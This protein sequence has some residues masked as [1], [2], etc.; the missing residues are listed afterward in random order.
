MFKLLVPACLSLMVMCPINLQAQDCGCNH[1]GDD[2]YESGDD[3]DSVP[4][5]KRIGLIESSIEIKK[6]R[7]VCE[8]DECGNTRYRLACVSEPFTFKRLGLVDVPVD[9][10]RPSFLDQMRDRMS[11]LSLRNRF[12]SDECCDDCSEGDWGYESDYGD[13]TQGHFSRS[14]PDYDAE[15]Y[16]EEEAGY[17][18]GEVVPEGTIYR[19]TTPRMGRPREASPDLGQ[20]REP[21]SREIIPREITPRGIA[22]RNTNPSRNGNDN[23]Y[24]PQKNSSVIESPTEGNESGD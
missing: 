7:R 9:P 17:E 18:Y 2:W 23:F 24:V 8:T 12:S 5:R 11:S 16:F 1:R 22:P 13:R 20:P 4:T 14:Y 3:W 15:E 21:S 19:E 6:L 10:C